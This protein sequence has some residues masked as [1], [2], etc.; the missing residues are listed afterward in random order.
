MT[1]RP[2]FACA[3]AASLT[4]MGGCATSSRG[5]SD[6][7]T[8]GT[9]TEEAAGISYTEIEHDGRIYVIGNED[10]LASFNQT[11]HLP[12]TRTL[13]GDGPNGETVVLEISKKDEAFNEALYA[14]YRERHPFYRE[15]PHD[16][17]LYVIGD[18]DTLSSFLTTHHLPYTRTLIGAGPDGQTVVLEVSKKDEA[19]NERLFD[20]YSERHPFYREIPHN[21]R[22]YVVGSQDAL[23]SFL[24]THHL[25]YTRTLIGDGPNGETVV[26]EISKKDQE[27]NERLY[28]TYRERHPFYREI[29]HD[30]RIY[31]VGSSDSMS[32]FLNSH[33]LPYTRTFIGAGPERQTLV[34][35]IAK[36]DASLVERLISTFNER[37]ST[38]VA[39]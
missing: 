24:T 8:A 16:G 1:F 26:L 38:S 13:I 23:S 3:V 20:T 22:I 15:I 21:G 35:E 36:K 12:Y 28:N 34:F 31:V 10:T 39:Q 29:P 6:T 25:P 4:L 30:G 27:Y 37:N 14:A 11:H 7:S 32:D 17:R 19:F 5:D 9:A 18:E 2:L 33:H